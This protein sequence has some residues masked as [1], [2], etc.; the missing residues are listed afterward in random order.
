[1]RI[2]LATFTFLSMSV[3]PTGGDGAARAAD[4]TLFYAPGSTPTAAP[5]DPI[6][7]GVPPG[8]G[9]G[10]PRPGFKRF[11]APRGRVCFSPAE[12]RDKIVAHRLTEPFRALRTGRLQGE[13]LR[14]RLC[15]WKPDQ[16][17]YEIAVLR[18][19]GRIV[20]VYMNALNGQNVGAFGDFD[21]P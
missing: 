7:T 6:V 14:A 2:A 12:T 10:L 11:E 13:A 3:L 20:H 18:R 17:V 21:R 19:D 8:P 1:M 16:F 9:L 15:R 4:A 5:V